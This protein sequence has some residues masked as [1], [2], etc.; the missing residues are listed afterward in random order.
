LIRKKCCWKEQSQPCTELFNRQYKTCK[1]N[2]QAI[3][4]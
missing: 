1:L 2:F 3:K 4:H